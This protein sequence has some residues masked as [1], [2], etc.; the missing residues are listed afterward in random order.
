MARD[1]VL[2]PP[3]PKLRASTAAQRRRVVS[4]KT[5]ESVRYFSAMTVAMSSMAPQYSIFHK[6]FK[7]FLLAS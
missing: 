1:T 2:T 4:F 7:L 5:P 6:V 3:C